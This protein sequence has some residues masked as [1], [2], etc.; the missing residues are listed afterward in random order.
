MRS[1]RFWL[2]WLS[3]LLPAVAAAELPEHVP[4]PGGIAV[5]DVGVHASRPAVHF[6]DRQ[7]LVMQ[8]EGR[9]YAIV[10]VPLAA[11]PGGHELTIRG[12]AENRVSFEVVPHAYREQRLNVERRYVE[13]DGEQLERILGERRIIDAA[14]QNFRAAPLDSLTLSPPVAGRRSDSFGF[15]RFFNDQPRAPHS[16]MDI[17]ASQGTPVHAARDG[18]VAATGHYFFNGKTVIIDHGLGLITMYCHL[19]RIDVEASARVRQGELVGV[20]G[21]TGRVTGAHLH[22]GAYLTGT[23]ID[24]ALLLT[25]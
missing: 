11:E 19:D 5:V 6:G 15:R 2:L 3:W 14:L 12:A 16:G 21:A 4:K 7:T 9:W 8:E 20:V 13:P 10:G 23:A 22:F 25:D 18:V 24:P 17:R 1:A